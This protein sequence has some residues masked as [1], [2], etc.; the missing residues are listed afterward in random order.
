MTPRLPP[1]KS[2][3]VPFLRSFPGNEAHKLFSGGPKW[4]VSGGGPKV[5]VEKVYVLFPSPNLVSQNA[6]FLKRLRLRSVCICVLKCGLLR[7]LFW[8]SGPKEEVAIKGLAL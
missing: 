3:W 2:M 5:Y 6:A 7:H 8:G 4:G 1:K